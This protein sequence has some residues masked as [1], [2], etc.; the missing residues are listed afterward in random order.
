MRVRVWGGWVRVSIY[1]VIA[2]TIV[3][4]FLK[5]QSSGRF[6]SRVGVG[7]EGVGVGVDENNCHD[8]FRP[9]KRTFQMTL[10]FYMIE[11]TRIIQLY[12]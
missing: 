10:M 1:K 7:C 4:T 3:S 2:T 8:R 12:I 6:N 5:G 9:G 11:I